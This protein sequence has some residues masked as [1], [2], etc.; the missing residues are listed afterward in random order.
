MS[1][2]AYYKMDDAAGQTVVLDSS[3]NNFTGTAANN[4]T[5]A[6]GKVGSAI[7]FNGTSDFITISHN[8]SFNFGANT[9][10]SVAT[11]IKTTNTDRQDITGK[12]A[13]QAGHWEVFINS[14]VVGAFIDDGV[15][16][17]VTTTDGT[18]V[19]DGL[20]HHIAVT[21]DRTG[22]IIR[23]VDGVQTGTKDAISSIGDI[24]NTGD[25]FIGVRALGTG[26]WYD[27]DI[28]DLRIY[29][30]VLTPSQIAGLIGTGRYGGGSRNYRRSRF[31]R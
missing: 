4:I 27:G 16:T 17:V 7:T 30:E 28:D 22:N 25:Q 23:Y 24:D 14:N 26:V 20:W 8:S 6:G 19:T 31:N 11:W 29:N 9:D 2:I 12:D 13:T 1:L 10:F 3:G 5:S 18:V 15:N 21:F